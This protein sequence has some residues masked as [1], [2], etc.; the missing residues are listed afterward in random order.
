MNCKDLTREPAIQRI[1]VT[2]GV[3]FNDRQLQTMTTKLI[4]HIA[5]LDIMTNITDIACRGAV[6]RSAVEELFKDIPDIDWDTLPLDALYGCLA[7]FVSRKIAADESDNDMQERVWRVINELLEDSL[8]QARASGMIDDIT[9]KQKPLSR[10]REQ[11]E[12]AKPTPIA[13]SSK[14]GALLTGQACA[15]TTD[16]PTGQAAQRHFEPQILDVVLRKQEDRFLQLQA[17]IQ[18]QLTGLA[19][20][21]HSTTH[22]TQAPGTQNLPPNDI[23]D[24]ERQIL[25]KLLGKA[26]SSVEDQAQAVNSFER[27]IAEEKEKGAMT[28]SDDEMSCARSL[29]TRD[30]KA[31]RY[32][33]SDS[34]FMN[35]FTVATM[36]LANF[37]QKLELYYNAVL[38]TG[39][40]LYDDVERMEDAIATLKTSYL[41]I[42][43]T[44][45]K[46]SA[47]LRRMV[48]KMFVRAAE[49]FFVVAAMVRCPDDRQAARALMREKIRELQVQERIKP[50]VVFD[51]LEIM[52]LVAEKHGSFLSNAPRNRGNQGARSRSRRRFGS[53]G[54]AARQQQQQQQQQGPMQQQ[55]Q[56]Q[57][58]QPRN[59]PQPAAPAAQQSQH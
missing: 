6:V 47:I 38:R 13:D 55:H 33:K 12:A 15:Q 53:T 54:L 39:K 37:E 23:T 21:L 14:D 48:Y 26:N 51:L 31:K 42:A 58:Q 29:E 24:T 41:A 9:V 52:R 30:K 7:L 49:S 46:T 32:L 45:E 17:S 34:F 44:D 18:A 27:Y 50:A 43:R 36:P 59:T 56:Q 25:A 5:G 35:P 1:M 28:D 19:Q 57:R 16:S 8:A 3:K 40:P 20:T 4:K 11:T 10:K 2:T 22:H